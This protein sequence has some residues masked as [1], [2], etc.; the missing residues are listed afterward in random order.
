[1]TQIKFGT[2]GWRA[3]IADDFTFENLRIVTSAFIQSAKPKSL[4]IGYDNRFQSEHFARAAAEVC[5]KNGIKV[6]LTKEAVPT[7][8]LSFAVKHYKL[9]AGIMITASH[10]PADWNGFKIKEYFGGS[11]RPEVTKAVESAIEAVGEIHEFPQHPFIPLPQGEGGPSEGRWVREAIEFINPKLD[12]FKHVE[13][14]VDLKAI[15][16]SKVKIFVD[17]MYGSG[18]HYIKEILKPYGAE[19]EELH[20]RRDPLFGGVNP[21]PLPVN[22]ID[23]ISYLKTFD[24]IFSACI[25]LD[26]DG[27][28][29]AAIDPSGTYLSSHNVFSLILYHLVLNRKLT[30]RIVKTFNISRLIEKQAKK[31]NLEIIETPIGFKYIAD[32]MMQN[33][34]ENAKKRILIG[35]EESGG[36]GIQGHLPERDGTLNGLLLL[37]LMAKR[38][39]NLREIL[40]EI[41]D[42]LGYYFYDR[43]DLHLKNVGEIHELP[44]LREIKTN[45]PQTFAG[46]KVV[47]VESLD[48]LKL[49]FDDESWIL[50]RPSGTEPLIRI[51]AE[52]RTEDETR[53][54]LG[55]GEKMLIS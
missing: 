45:P 18:A 30:G 52:A 21:E 3:R 4:A 51:Y 43:I 19:V 55:E 50:F 8:A 38:G 2:D 5:A 53:R 9:S 48:G 28:R 46:R 24:R 12:Y 1:M 10:N 20:C 14:L 15:A 13:K 35:G 25:V 26:G 27:D 31:Y 41:M 6:F 39:I 47:K 42:E 11:A 23:T 36:I 44:R 17:P 22:L 54:I 16:A 49:N 33:E 34:H 40:K 7:P 29:L 32:L 37:E